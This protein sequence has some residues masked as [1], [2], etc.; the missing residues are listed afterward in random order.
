VCG[1]TVK[2]SDFGLASIITGRMRSHR[3]AGTTLYAAPE[4]FQG[5]LSD[6]TDQY[7]L[8][9]TYCELR[10]GH[11]PFPAAPARFDRRYV[12]PPPDLAMLT[13]AERPIVRRALNPVPQDRWPSCGAL[14]G[15]LTALIT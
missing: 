5:R 12:P 8:A 3:R 9:V 7:S 13:L 6:R 15:Q 1:D 11:L 4:V 2:L 14:V 10:T